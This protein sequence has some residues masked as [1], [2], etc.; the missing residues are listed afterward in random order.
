M[1]PEPV[2]RTDRLPKEY[3]RY[4]ASLR[5]RPFVV[6]TGAVEGNRSGVIVDL[7]LTSRTQRVWT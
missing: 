3:A 6:T 4:A 2:R 7:F 1:S 5:D